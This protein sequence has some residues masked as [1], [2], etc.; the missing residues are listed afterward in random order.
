[1]MLMIIIII[2]ISSSNSNNVILRVSKLLQF[3]M[4]LSRYFLF[5]GFRW[6]YGYECDMYSIELGV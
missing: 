1:M 2:I 5:G 3:I 6:Y 4:V